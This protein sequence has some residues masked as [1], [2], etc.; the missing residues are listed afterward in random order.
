MVHISQYLTMKQ[1]A[2]ACGKSISTFYKY[3]ENKIGP[4]YH[5][6]G[7][8]KVFLP[9]HLKEWKPPVDGRI[10]NAKNLRNSRRPKRKYED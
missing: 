1:A 5:M 8:R 3:L 7:G 9:E 6:L 10:N 2:E 4:E